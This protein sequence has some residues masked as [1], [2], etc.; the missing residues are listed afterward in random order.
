[1]M[2]I[3]SPIQPTS[4]LNIMPATP[5]EHLDKNTPAPT[6]TD[7][8]DS[9]SNNASPFI[10]APA[11]VEAPQSI[12]QVTKQRM[13]TMAM[14]PGDCGGGTNA[15][16]STNA[17]SVGFNSGVDTCNGNGSAATASNTNN[18]ISNELKHILSLLK[19]P[20]LISRDYEGQVEDETGP[21]DMLYDYSSVDAWMNFPVKRS[22]PNDDNRMKKVKQIRDLYAVF[23]DKNA[24]LAAANMADGDVEMRD[25]EHS[26]QGIKSEQNTGRGGGNARE[27]RNE[28]EIKK[29]NADSD[30]DDKGIENLYT[31]KGLMASYK[32][33]DQIFDNVDDSPL[34]VS[35]RIALSPQGFI[36]ANPSFISN[37]IS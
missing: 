14:T 26:A 3:I 22:R 19:R 37:P 7:Q 24:R 31:S 15:G 25:G 17:K 23:E 35:F 8:Q 6:P 21:R 20:S 18:G 5:I 9:K 16:S 33:L 1:M 10:A 30:V 32:D 34:G 36:I 4:A 11:S 27:L 2:P 28:H 13:E 12:E 29:E